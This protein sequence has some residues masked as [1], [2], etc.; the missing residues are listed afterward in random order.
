MTTKVVN[1][2]PKIRLPLCLS[3]SQAPSA[4]PRPRFHPMQTFDCGA[5][6]QRVMR[7]LQIPP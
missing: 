2:S 1:F 3:G 6:S 5:G 4:R 7:P